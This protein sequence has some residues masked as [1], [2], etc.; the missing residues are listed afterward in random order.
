MSLT[1]KPPVLKTPEWATVIE[2]RS[3]REKYHA[4]IGQA[5]NAVG[6]ELSRGARGGQVYRWNATRDSWVLI[7]DVAPGTKTQDLPWNKKEQD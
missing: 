7:W 6:Y 5:K 1:D 3:P 4:T 2:G